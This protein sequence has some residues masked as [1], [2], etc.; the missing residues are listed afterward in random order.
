MS[1]TDVGNINTFV[2]CEIDKLTEQHSS[3]FVWKCYQSDAPQL[4]I[5]P[6]TLELMY[7]C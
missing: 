2:K 3:P 7:K 1:I 4:N 6:M 5:Y